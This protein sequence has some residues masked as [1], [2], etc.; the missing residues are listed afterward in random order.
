M[1]RSIF[2]WIHSPACFGLPELENNRCALCGNLSVDCT[3]LECD[4]PVVAEDKEGKCGV[5]GCL[6]HLIDR[7]LVNEIE[8]LGSRLGDLRAE[9][10]RRETP[11]LPCPVCGEV[12]IIN[13][14]NS[15]PY[16]CHGFFYAGD[17]H[18]W[19][20]KERY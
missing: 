11:S 16:Q 5:R 14:Y 10:Q 12:Q 8:I 4:Y 7:D 17:K 3:C 1:T 13:I 2:S 15:G 20:K 18:G 9:A 19:I 6:E